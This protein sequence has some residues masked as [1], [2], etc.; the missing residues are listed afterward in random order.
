MAVIEKKCRELD[1]RVVVANPEAL[2]CE[3]VYERFL[4][5]GKEYVTGIP[6]FHQIE[7]ASLAILA[8]RELGIEE[9]FIRSGVLRA[10]NPA[11]FE[12]IRENPTVIYDG[13]HNENG[14]MALNFTLHR[15]F[16]EVDKTVIFA[17]MKDKEIDKSLSL[18]KEGKTEFIFTTVKDNSRAMSAAELKKKAESYG[19][20]GLAYEEIGEAYRE[21]ISRGNLTV[22]CGSLYLYKDFREFYDK[23][24]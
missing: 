19:F 3:G 11:R 13:G 4:L 10:R 18:L 8:A 15:Y 12:I 14:I 16:G 9:S 24:Y 1:T 6:G 5:D 21:A 17:C 2:S 23:E 22:I 7:N 20:S